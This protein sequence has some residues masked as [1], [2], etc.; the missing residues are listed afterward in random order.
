MT[1]IKRSQI[2]ATTSFLVII[3]AWEFLATGYIPP[4]SQVFL[5]LFN[6]ITNQY[7]LEN[8][9]ISLVRLSTGWVLGAVLGTLIGVLMATSNKVKDYAMPLV[10]SIFPIP[11]IALLPLI[12]VIFG[13]GEESKILIIAVGAFFPSI[14]NAFTSI[15]KTPVEYIEQGLDL[16]L[17]PWQLIYLILVPVNLPQLIQGCRTSANLSLTLLVAAE[18]LGSEKGL[19]HW[20]LV[21]GGNMLYDQ[22]LA[23]IVCLSI[24]GLLI[25]KIV[26][27]C[28]KFFCPWDPAITDKEK[29]NVSGN[30]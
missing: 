27:V 23:G 14:I 11:K 25:S 19:G 29:Y 18:M 8:L 20:I 2:R 1:K 5:T 24:L 16:G 15:L 6:L 3:F 17:K 22:M 28:H 30:L 26:D 12:M 4:C 21:S 13:L 9:S 7:F 10:S